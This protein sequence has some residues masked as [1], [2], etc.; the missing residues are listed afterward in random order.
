MEYEP[1]IGLEIHVELK[2]RTKM[3]CSCLNDSREEI[4]NINICP[5]CLGHPGTL[6]T[7][8]QEAVRLVLKT[9]LSLNCQ[10]LPL[11]KF[12]R[13]N[14]FYPDLPKGYQISQY[15]KPLCL[16][17]ELPL[18]LAEDE[19]TYNKK[20][21]IKRIHLEEDTGKLIHFKDKKATFI[22]FNRA[23]VPLMELVTYPVIHS[24]KE[25]R[26][27][28]ESLQLLLKELNVSEAE[29]EKGQMR[30]EVN[31]SL[32]K[33]GEEKLGTKVEIKNL[34]SF[35]AVERAIDFEIERQKEL[36]EKG[37]NIIQET[38]GWDDFKGVTYSQRFK[39]EAQ[40]YRYF[41]E[42]DLPPLKVFE[43]FDFEKIKQELKELPWERKERLMRDYNLNLVSANLFLKEPEVLSFYERT[44]LI[45]K[46]KGLKDQKVFQLAFNYLTTDL[47]GIREK[48]KISFN[49]LKITPVSF[50]QIITLIIDN[51]IS[52]RV[53]K[54]LLLEISLSGGEP[55]K[56][57]KEKN[58]EKIEDQNLIEE[59]VKEVINENPKAVNDFKNG[60]ENALQFLIGQAMRKL[61]GAVDVKTLSQIIV[62]KI[63]SL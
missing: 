56:I 63:K 9:G 24:S 32:R 20:I 34:N 22:D 52:S 8:N 50:S 53:A 19:E 4:P 33:K 55:E 1:V 11:S 30:C 26:V 31:I 49:E 10:I 7:I 14:Y 47:L 42:P 15:D 18:F 16:E 48:N 27:F 6:P 59:T 46:E 43:Y 58:L 3:F 41:P 54:D 23:G 5:I 12:D 51:K 38:R 29:M 40:D 17:G 62:E 39:E 2:T 35:R 25:A 21:K 61:K 28:A 60:K 13:K 57:I 45:L 44:I 37:E 36:L